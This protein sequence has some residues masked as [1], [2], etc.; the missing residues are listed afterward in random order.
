GI[1]QLSVV[2]I[3]AEHTFWLSS[4]AAQGGWYEEDIRL[5]V[6]NGRSPL[7]NFTDSEQFDS[8]R[9]V[10]YRCLC[11]AHNWRQLVRRL[12]RAWMPLRSRGNPRR[13]PRHASN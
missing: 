11:W 1:D 3:S 5:F 9:A 10:R 8:I 6:R 2:N 13:Q 4:I 12:R 7:S